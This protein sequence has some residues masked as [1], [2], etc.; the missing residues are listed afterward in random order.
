M[1][2]E[3][4]QNRTGVE[5]GHFIP[6]R[7][8]DIVEMCIGDGAVEAPEQAGFR[9]FCRI[10]EAYFHYEYHGRL[11]KLKNCY[12]PL[13]P[14][15]DTQADERPSGEELIRCEEGFLEMLTKVLTGANYVPMSRS[16][17]EQSLDGY[18]R[19][20]IRLRVDL[21]DFDKCLVFVR[22]RQTKSEKVRSV[23]GLRAKA[24]E[25]E[26]YDRVV[27]YLR[28]KAREHFKRKEIRDA[29][30]T[31]GE[32]YLKLFKDVAAEDIETIY[33]NARLHM[34]MI[35][36]LL[37]GVPAAAG[38]LVVL[39]TKLWVVLLMLL[40][41]IAF[42]VGLSK[43]HVELEQKHLVALAM[44]LGALGGYIFRQVSKVKS[45][46]LRYL[47]NLSEN[48]YFKVLDN[49]AG[50]F[51]HLIDDAEEED[52][53]EA[54]LA[55][56]FLATRKTDFTEPQLDAEI[57]KWFAESHGVM[58]DFEVDDAMTK[59]ERLGLAWREGRILRVKPLDQAKQRIDYLWDNFFSFNQP[60]ES[61]T[62]SG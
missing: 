52:C 61:N 8:A 17:I 36:K 57:E 5:A 40:A 27:I 47:K 37:V 41:L 34:R 35:D 15:A 55:Y 46:K 4:D 31:P 22:G 23:P 42:W 16:E 7:K 10:L 29:P 38:G 33:P 51:H 26:Y 19:F 13:N 30:F 11:E 24:V 3:P 14:D 54:F 53:K 12:A 6:F 39:F 20:K 44:G 1:D 59:L 50:V 28:L 60:D 45:R 56:Y 49:N 32:S 2:Q 25:V 48:L 43:K 21:E 58:L 9:E 62:V 18:T